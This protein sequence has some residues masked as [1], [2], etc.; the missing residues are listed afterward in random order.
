MERASKQVDRQ[1]GNQ[2]SERGSI[3][4]KKG[5]KNGG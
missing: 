4:D 3:M 1:A 2:P 5:V